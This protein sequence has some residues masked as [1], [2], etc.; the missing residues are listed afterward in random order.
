MSTVVASD[1]QRRITL[2][3]HIQ[4]R[5]RFTVTRAGSRI[6]LRFDPE[7]AV[8]ADERSRIRLTADLIAPR[9]HFLLHTRERGIVLEP[10]VVLA[11][12]MIDAALWRRIVDA[13]SPEQ[14]PASAD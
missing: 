12:S 4:P 11:E 14:D 13:L 6:V 3:K 7:G 2:G 10:C 8:H 5:Q 1:A 9:A